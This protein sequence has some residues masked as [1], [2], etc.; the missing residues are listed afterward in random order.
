M[1]LF[2]EQFRKIDS[3]EELKKLCEE[4]P[5]YDP[6]YLCQS[7]YELRKKTKDWLEDLWQQYAPHADPHFLE[8]FR[9]SF[10]QRCWELYLGNTFL[11]HKFR[12]GE[13]KGEGPDFD[14]RDENDQRLA[15]VE[16]I[17]VTQ[18]EGPD[19]VPDAI[20][21]AVRPVPTDEI[22]LRIAHG[23][24]TKY[25]KYCKDVT[26]GLIKDDEP[27][28]IALDRSTA[29]S[30]DTLLPNILK[31]VFGIG[32]LALRMRIGGKP[33]ENPENVWTHQP[34]LAK[35]NGEQISMHFFDDPTH[36]GVSAVIYATDHVISSPRKQQEMGENFYIVHNPLAKNPLP[37]GVLSFWR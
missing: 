13:N 10:T 2:S 11:N 9:S 7:T 31:A 37:K 5:K 19:R 4:F 27:Y 30:V 1:K 22:V 3:D 14:L 32:D 8:E 17:A 36:A 20:Y 28:V 23:L 18:G 33:V 26:K 35:Q 21:E 34:V 6:G 25:K 24:E 15:W 12:L 16:A 29:G